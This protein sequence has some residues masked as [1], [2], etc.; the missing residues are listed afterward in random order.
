[1]GPSQ[2]AAAR[3]GS[4]IHS[5]LGAP[6]KRGKNGEYKMYL[7]SIQII[8][9]LGK[10]SLVSSFFERPSRKGKKTVM[11]KLEEYIRSEQQLGRIAS[12]VGPQFAASLMM[13]S[14][15]FRAFVDNFFGK[16]MQPGWTKFAKELVATVA[17]KP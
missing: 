1:L 16:S 10:G 11:V 6:K 3:F 7:N 5:P 13:S 9:F 15:F 12:H 17:P 8:G 4:S 14:S 2:N